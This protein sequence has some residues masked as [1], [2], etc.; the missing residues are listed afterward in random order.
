MSYSSKDLKCVVVVV[1]VVVVVFV[2]VVVVIVRPYLLS[3]HVSSLLH[4]S[5][6]ICTLHQFSTDY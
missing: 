1:V 2:V 3:S 6:L 5:I 4:R